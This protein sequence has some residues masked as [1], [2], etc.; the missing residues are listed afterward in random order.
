MDMVD[1]PGKTGTKERWVVV[2]AALL[3][4][5]VLGTVYAFS[6]FRQ[7]LV[8]RFGWSVT[9]VS[10]AFTICLV[11]FTA[12]TIVA[13]RWQD[14]V[15]PR[16]VATTGAVLLG[17][18]LMLASLTRS[19]P[20]LYLAYGVVAGTGIGFGYVTPLAALVK[21]FPDHR[22]LMTGL[23]VCGFG[24]GSLIFAPLATWLI[25]RGGVLSAFG[26][27]GLI[28]LVLGT[29]AARLLV[30]PPSGVAG[31]EAAGRASS[32]TASRPSS[33]GFA[34][35]EMVRTSAFWLLWVEYVVGAGAGL[36]VISQAAPLAGELA[37]ASPAHAAAMVWGAFSGER[38]PTGWD[39]PDP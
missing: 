2:G 4:Q 31:G 24:A 11:S 10:A 25:A 21:W 23:A 34:P 6:V 14:A 36:M 35:G 33:G 20:W 7:P 19:L 38:S 26:W 27:L 28:F 37:H 1:M 39:E 5:M 13:G 8:Q 32:L 22:G 3:L 9:S 18:G 12:A 30:D 16:P 17:S 15:G 29:G